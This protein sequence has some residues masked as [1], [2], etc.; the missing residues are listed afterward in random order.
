MRRVAAFFLFATMFSCNETP[1]PQKPTT[2]TATQVEPKEVVEETPVEEPVEEVVQIPYSAEPGFLVVNGVEVDPK[3]FN[4]KM[5]LIAS[6]AKVVSPK[7]IERYRDSAVDEI[8]RKT[9]LE[10]AAKEM[11]AS[12]AEVEAMIERVKIGVSDYDVHLQKLGQTDEEFRA[13]IAHSI[14][15]K[16]LVASRVKLTDEEIL[17]YY[18]KNK[19]RLAEDEQIRASHILLRVAQDATDAQKKEIKKKARKIAADA[20]KPGADFAKLAKTH[21]EGP[22]KKKGGD[23]GWFNRKRMMRDFSIAAFALKPGEVSRPVRSEH[24]YH[25]IKTFEKKEASTPTFDQVKKEIDE[26]MRGKRSKTEL[27]KLVTELKKKAK[28][29]KDKKKIVKNEAFKLEEPTHR[30]PSKVLV[31]E[32]KE[33]KKKP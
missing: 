25:I 10:Q 7:D 16:K 11:S 6:F 27:R 17:A 14:R 24:G 31:P 29:K 26:T 13:E 9:L 8:V 4:Q 3:H 1:S 33:K 28:V 5:Q 12:D 23:L 30:V 2:E 19:T 21:S 18:E 22:T 32:K 20:R 15:V